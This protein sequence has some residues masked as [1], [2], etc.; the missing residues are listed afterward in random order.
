MKIP[1][2]LMLVAVL[3]LVAACSGDG[4]DSNGSEES[5]TTVAAAEDADITIQDFSFGQ[6]L[7]VPVGTTVTVT[8]EDAVS[9]TWTADDDTFD[10]GAL[11]T[12]DSFDFTFD[13][14][15]EYT[16][17]CE[18]HPNMTGSITVEG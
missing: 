7:S 16:F 8:N 2:V 10:S 3:S 12:D 6:A 1:R 15:G 5:Q 14:A 11:A 17:V 4:N 18:F 9:H 13:E